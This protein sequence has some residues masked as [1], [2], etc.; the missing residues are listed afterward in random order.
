MQFFLNLSFGCRYNEDQ[1]ILNHF[2]SKSIENILKVQ[3]PLPKNHE[4]Q[5]TG[6]WKRRRMRK[7]GNKD[8]Y[9]NKDITVSEFVVKSIIKGFN[10]FIK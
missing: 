8:S 7:P 3:K 6:I 1:F 9:W 5:T 10:E 2:N 4:S